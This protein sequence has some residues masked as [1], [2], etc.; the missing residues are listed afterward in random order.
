MCQRAVQIIQIFVLLG[1]SNIIGIFYNCF[2]SPGHNSSYTTC[3]SIV[4]PPQPHTT[5]SPSLPV[6]HLHR[7]S[8]SP[9]PRARPLQQTNQLGKGTL[10]WMKQKT[11]LNRGPGWHIT[12]MIHGAPEGC[13]S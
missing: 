10:M 7:C 6:P 9:G 3:G 8:R 11:P 13:D 12:D 4:Q 5:R 2:I 1:V